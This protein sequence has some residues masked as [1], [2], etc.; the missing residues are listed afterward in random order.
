M[1]KQTVDTYTL[2][3]SNQ[4]QR[5]QESSPT[6][7]E[8]NYRVAFESLLLYTTTTFIN[9][10]TSDIDEGIGKALQAIG[11][12]EGVD[13]AYVMLFS[14]DGTTMETS[15]EWYAR[16]KGIQQHR[17]KD[18]LLTAFAWSMQRLMRGEVL[19]IPRVAN[20]PPE[21]QA[22]RAAFER[23]NIQ[24]LIAVPLFN[25]DKPVGFL[26]F[27][28]IHAEKQWTDEGISLL[29]ILGQILVNVLQRKCTEDAL[30]ESERR[31]LTLMS[32]LPGMAYRCRNTPSWQMEFVSEG[33]RELTGYAP[34]AFM[35]QQS[36]AYNEL[37]HPDDR[38]MVWDTVQDALHKEQPFR[39]TYRI[40][41]ASGDTRWV[42]EQGRAIYETEEKESCREPIAI[43]LEGFITDVTERVSLQ[44]CLE[45]RV[46]ERTHELTT[47]LNVQQALTSHL[48]PQAVA[49]MIAA[50]AQ[51]LTNATFSTVFLQE[52]AMLRVSILVG[53]YRPDFYVGYCMPIEGSASGQAM[54]TRQVVHVADAWQD[55]RPNRDAIGR[56]QIRSLIA[57]PLMAGSTALGTITVGHREPGMFSDKDERVLTLLVPGA[58]IAME[59]AHYYHQEQQRRREIEALYRADEE[60]YRHLDLDQV[61][62]SLVDVVIDILQADKSAVVVCDEQRSVV[63]AARGFR[64]ESLTSMILLACQDRTTPHALDR[65]PH[66]I[67]DIQHSP[68]INR[69]LFEREHISSLVSMPVTI[70]DQLF[71]VFHVGYT[72]PRTFGKQD[73]R[74]LKVLAQR[75]ALAI[76][77]ARFHQQA[78]HT[79]A[80]EERQRLARDLHDAV[81][82]TLFSASLVAEVLPLLWE[83]NP[84]EGQR[85]LYELRQMTR[86]ALAEMRSLLLE[87]RPATLL[88]ASMEDLLRQLAEAISGRLQI[89]VKLDITPTVPIPV[90]VKIAFYRIAQESL[91]NVARHARASQAYVTLHM[92]PP[93][94][95]LRV[96]DNG[97]G[98]NVHR[99][100]SGHLG[101]GI[102]RERAEAVG[103]TFRV[104]SSAEWGTEITVTWTP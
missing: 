80:M 103:A 55:S 14:E 50:E 101:L 64:P 56:A 104:S 66:I 19:H 78:Q 11:T 88:E 71:G 95:E 51:R 83:Q 90:E 65:E 25:G 59:N 15:H 41:T 39:I 73:H 5:E 7:D 20:L 26:G 47:L 102:M 24:S 93:H 37:I 69:T 31:L 16:E 94:I 8:L 12:F 98:F 28:S 85:R 18:R 21:A 46:E 77:N 100:P 63:R 4:Q 1:S 44:Q 29:K 68:H 60:L 62:Q 2:P 6:E 40:I 87:L 86:G 96:S 72:H 99:V 70:G 45:Q 49:Q 54:E 74:L 53:D 22:E 3:I 79:A 32:N 52:E 42:W 27:D 89:P 81:T 30:R 17:V 23:Q 92:V 61:L 84:N 91:N 35:D 76:E 43:A 34:A 97:C 36:F 58:V 82:Q 48:D 75:A 9:L 57:V 10:P 13:R 33:S 67:E 38:S